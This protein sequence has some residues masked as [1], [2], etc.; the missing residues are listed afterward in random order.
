[1]K[2]FFFY[3]LLRKFFLKMKSTYTVINAS[4]GSGKTYTLVQRLLMLCLENPSEPDAVRHIIAL[5]FTN[6]AANE[7]KER[8]LQWLG[9]FTAENYAQCQELLDI[10]EKFRQQGKNIPIDELHRRSQAVLDYILHHYSMLNI[11]T[12]DRFNSKL[13]RSFSYELGLAQNFNLEIQPEPY[14]I[15]A[16]DQ[17]LDKIGGD[18]KVS[19]T[20]ID[21][22]NYSLDNNERVNL[23][24]TLYQSAKEFVKDIHYK[25]LLENKDFDWEAYENTKNNIRKNLTEIKKDSVKIA[26]DTISLIKES[27]AKFSMKWLSSTTRS[28]KI[29]LS[30]RMKN[31][32]R[33]SLKKALHPNQNKRSRIF[34]T[35][36][37]I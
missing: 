17:M 10:Q 30:H 16:V 29:S 26:Q 4:A 8:I 6:K 22:V 11:G 24:Q 15:E 36:S 37:V 18:K 34:L 23:S 27:I 12:I 33:Q 20:F 3:L 21:F 7:M 5:T 19:E 31:L 32:H 35:F 1:M 25:R 13:V 14:L 2:G 28:E 9:K